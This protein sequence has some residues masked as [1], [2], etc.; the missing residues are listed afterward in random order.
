[1]PAVVQ[2]IGHIFHEQRQRLQSL[3]IVQIAQIQIGA[4]INLERLRMLRDFAQLG[5][6]HARVCL[7]GGAPDDDVDRARRCPQMEVLG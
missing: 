3:D 4:G 5:S 6:A 1:M 2:D 7:A